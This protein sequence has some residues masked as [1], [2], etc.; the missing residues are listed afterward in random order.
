MRRESW[1]EDAPREASSYWLKSKI[2]CSTHRDEEF[3]F[4]STR[5]DRGR[6]GSGKRSWHCVHDS[7]F[8]TLRSKRHRATVPRAAPAGLARWI[9]GCAWITHK[10]SSLKLACKRRQG[11]PTTADAVCGP[12]IDPRKLPPH[13]RIRILAENPEQHSSPP[14]KFPQI[15]NARKAQ[16]LLIMRKR[17][18][19]SLVYY[20]YKF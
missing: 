9:A 1:T 17:G 19:N 5:L 18:L 13:S 15:P 16:R 3:D 8:V 14:K 20:L 10:A 7:A 12:R 6:S 4:R 11:N 2:E